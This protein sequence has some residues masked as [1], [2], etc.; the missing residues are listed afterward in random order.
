MNRASIIK[1]IIFAAVAAA[2]GGVWAE[3]GKVGDYTWTCRINGNT[4]EIL[5]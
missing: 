4:S 2:A 3:T 5:V 1:S